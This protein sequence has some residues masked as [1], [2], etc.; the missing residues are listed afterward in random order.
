M[1]AQILVIDDD[2]E[3][4]SFI[5]VLL[6]GQGYRVY[7]A[8]TAE[9]ALEM[10][11]ENPPDLLISDVQ[12]PGL[13]GTR[14]CELLKSQPQT[15]TLPVILLTVMGTESDK[16]RGLKIGADDYL[17]KPFSAAELSA[18]V[19]A[20]L[21]RVRHAGQ[22]T[23]LL[24]LG[25]LEVDLDRHEVRLR[26]KPVSLRRKEYDL[27]VLFLQK[28]GRVLTKNFLTEALWRDESIVTRNTLNVH[29]KNLRRKLGP[30]K[31]LIETVIGE[32]YKLREG[33]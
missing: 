17:T 28:K 13:P 4:A 11:R 12:L 10:V 6:S 5:K 22:T 27:L 3:N 7:T 2:R 26:G 9:R 16:V 18:R 31:N 21:R 24:S 14:L 30:Y 32:G 15:A 29:I 19:E 23:Q 20:L 8:S 1:K 25:N 33:Q